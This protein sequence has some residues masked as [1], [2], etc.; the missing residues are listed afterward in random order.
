MEKTSEEAHRRNIEHNKYFELLDPNAS[1]FT[2]QTFGDGNKLG[3]LVAVFEG[4][5]ALNK[6]LKGGAKL[7]SI[8]NAYKQ[9]A[10]VWATVNETDGTGRKIENILRVRAVWCE[11]D[12]AKDGSTPSTFPIAP[13]MVVETSPGNFHF[14]WLVADHWPTDQLGKEDFAAVLECMVA[15]YGSDKAA[16]DISRVLR[17]PGFMHRKNPANPHLVRITDDNG[18]RYTRQQIVAAFP[19]PT[20]E[21][22]NHNDESTRSDGSWTELLR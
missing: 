11:F 6:R 1:S 18:A 15:A 12:G 16:T 19:A 3:H 5:L 8:D 7:A 17:V 20:K 9:G 2:F 21:R 4:T 13:S 10:G 22:H 14:Y